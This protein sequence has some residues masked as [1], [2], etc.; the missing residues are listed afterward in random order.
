MLDDY[1][2]L[3]PAHLAEKAERELGETPERRTEA[4]KELRA[5]V[6]GE[7]DALKSRTDPL[8]LLRFLRAR[9][10]DVPAAFRLLRNYYRIRYEN[11][12]LYADLY[13]STVK[14][15]LDL[16]CLG[17]LP[18]ADAQ[19]RRVFVLRMGVFPYSPKGHPRREPAVVLHYF[20][21]IL[22]AISEEQVFAADS[23]TRKELRQPARARASRYSA[24]RTRRLAGALR[25]LGVRRRPSA[26]RGS[27]QGA[28]GIRVST[29]SGFS[30][31][32]SSRRRRRR[33]Q[34]FD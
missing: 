6:D 19:G 9:K 3:L 11:P 7:A 28:R 32:S 30:G 29:A 4:L 5:L 31:S 13:P 8:F 12:D 18:D 16:Q 17:F 1:G 22:E 20:D 27:F 24:V 2:D 26:E 21:G 15:V 34:F 25:Q 33:R 10:F 23:P 14:D